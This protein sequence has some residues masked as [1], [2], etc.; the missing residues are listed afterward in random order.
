MSDSAPVAPDPVSP[1]PV[2]ILALPEVSA[3]V[4]YGMF[5]LFMSAGRDWGLIV[6]GRPG[7]QFFVP[8]VTAETRAPIEVGN[9][10]WPVGP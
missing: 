6:E 10:V 5:D 8:R 7:R 4:V 3:S 1:L 2:G 9:G